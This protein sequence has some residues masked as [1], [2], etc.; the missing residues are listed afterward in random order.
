MNHFHSP[1]KTRW[2][3]GAVQKILRVWPSSTLHC[4]TDQLNWIKNK[5]T[6][7]T[8]IGGEVKI[9]A[10][11]TLMHLMSPTIFLVLD[12]LNTTEKIPSLWFYAEAIANQV[13]LTFCFMPIRFL[14]LFFSCQFA[15]PFLVATEVS[16]GSEFTFGPTSLKYVAGPFPLLN[17]RDYGRTRAL[18]MS[19]LLNFSMLCLLNSPSHR[20]STLVFPTSPFAKPW[21][22]FRGC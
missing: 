9:S 16:P 10:W 3:I 8:H 19:L 11:L 21:S 12:M 22:I 4:P 2:K 18:S 6:K 13:F 5:Q 20:Y 17:C 15:L 14:S 1:S 7:W